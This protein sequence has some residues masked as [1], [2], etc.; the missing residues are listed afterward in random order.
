[1]RSNLSS[2]EWAALV[3]Q[4]FP[5]MIDPAGKSSV[6]S[7]ISRFHE[8]IIEG[9]KTNRTST[10]WQRLHGEKGLKASVGS[11]RRYLDLHVPD[12]AGKPQPTVLR[13]D[14]PPGKEAQVDFGYL[15]LW[16]DPATGK[17]TRLYAF[18][19]VLSHSRHMFVLVVTKMDQ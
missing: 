6:F 5:E 9:L 3:R 11:F 12:R 15:G 14:P 1:M 16:T 17:Q 10:V 18:V 4:H 13:D 8:A 2:D 19:M 7:E